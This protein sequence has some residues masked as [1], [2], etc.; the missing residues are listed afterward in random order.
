M[1]AHI[2]NIDVLLQINN[3]IWIIDINNPLEPLYKISKKDYNLIK[4]NIYIKYN[5]LL[6]YNSNKFYF[7]NDIW[8]D[9][10]KICKKRKIKITDIVFSMAEFNSTKYINNS[11]YSINI[12]N[13][14]FLKNSLDDIYL[15]SSKEI[16]TSYEVILN[17]LY[18]KLSEIGISIKNIYYI[19]SNYNLEDNEDIIFAKGRLC[20]QHL[21]GL[22]TENNKFILDEI[23][24]YDE[25]SIY[26]N[27]LTS[28]SLIKNIND[29]LYVLYNRS[30][31]DIKTI[32]NNRI[33]KQL[34]ANIVY[35]SNNTFKR[36]SKKTIILSIT[37]FI[38]TFE[39]FA[40]K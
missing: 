31:D 20:L 38:K 27:R 14:S 19:N 11:D 5:N 13:I 25:I 2:F 8:N 17:K 7:P 29:Y 36:F 10:L 34:K 37:R 16:T 28:N 24:A 3:K 26:D 30:L 39:C 4:S 40:K 9:I 15:I 23:E 22:R 35:V 32:I 1:K 33:E 12:D 6:E 18:D 21:I